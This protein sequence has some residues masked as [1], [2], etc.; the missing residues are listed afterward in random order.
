MEKIPKQ[1]RPSYRLWEIE[2]EKMDHL[3]DPTDVTTPELLAPS[4]RRST[5]EWYTTA[6]PEA[7]RP[8][9]LQRRTS[10]LSALLAP[11]E[12]P[13]EVDDVPESLGSNLSSSSFGSQP[14]ALPPT[15]YQT[16]K[17]NDGE[18]KSSASASA[19]ASASTSSS[20]SSVRTVSR[21]RR[22]TRR[23]MEISV[24]SGEVAVVPPKSPPTT[25]PAAP[26]AVL[27]RKKSA[28]PPVSPN[29]RA[30]AKSAASAKKKAL[31][32]AAKAK[33]DAANPLT[34]AN[35][36]ERTTKSSGTMMQNTWNYSWRSQRGYYPNEPKKRNQDACLI[37]S[38]EETNGTAGYFGVYDGHGKYG[39][40]CS[41]Y[42]RDNLPKLMA[43][44]MGAGTSVNSSSFDTAYSNIYIDC[45]EKLHRTKR[46]DDSCSGTTAASAWIEKNIVKVANI[47]DSRV[48]VGRQ[49]T[50]ST[51]STS[52]ASSTHVAIAL[53]SDQT[54]Y[55]KDERERIKKT[56]ARVL[57]Y[58]MLEG[59]VPIH[60][61]WDNIELGVSVDE[62]GDPPR[63]WSATGKYPGNA[64]T[65]SI[66]DKLSEPLGVYAVP[67]LTTHQLTK[68][69]D[70]IVVASD[71]IWEF[72]T[73]Q[74]CLDI[75]T[76]AETLEE[77]CEKIVNEAY[78]LWITNEVRTDD[79][80]AIIVQRNVANKR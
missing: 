76:A 52:S 71:G 47:G 7:A 4:S 70:Y 46:I 43:R 60:E 66:G 24:L 72:I 78:R 28:P 10:E 57:T 23:T 5:T 41:E 45:N 42:V 68:E 51:S 64:F 3:K 8:R 80:T 44:T 2:Q 74:Q 39:D 17:S 67:E 34:K 30:R 27:K 48:I 77:G 9:S 26:V 21:K 11:L 35:I 12:D 25:P 29:M 36:L 32:D 62:E 20:G 63:V 49:R 54:P 59:T 73:N 1:R 55:R 61:N 6:L 65:R 14:E 79:I 22:A 38:E 15:T 16:G 37:L 53:S 40:K 56:G 18:T 31:E 69:D 13:D 75:I 19:S 50:S 58:D 33:Y